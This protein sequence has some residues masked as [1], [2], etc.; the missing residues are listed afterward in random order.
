VQTIKVRIN[1]LRGLKGVRRWLRAAGNKLVPANLALQE[2]FGTSSFSAPVDF[3]AA[4]DDSGRLFVVEQGGTIRVLTPGATT[5]APVYLDIRDRVLFSGERG[6]L[7][8]TFHPN[9]E[10]N[11]FFYVNYT[12]SGDGAT[13]ISRF[14][15]SPASSNSVNASSEK[16]L[17]NVDQPFTNHNGGQVAFGADG[18]LYIAL[19]DGGSG[20]DPLGHGQ[21]RSTL[22]GS[23][24]RIDVDRSSGSRNYSIPSDNPFAGNTR[25]FKEEIYAYGLRNPWR[26]SFDRPTG[27]LWCGD[28]GQGAR[29]EVDIIE[30]GGNYGWNIMEG[31]LCYS[32]SE[33]CDRT[34]L[35]LPVDDYGRTLGA[36]ITGGYVYRGALNPALEGL[37]IFG[38]FVSGR[39]F[40]LNYTD[41]VASRR[42]LFDTS[43]LI[44]SFGVDRNG[45]L[46]MLSYGDGK[47][48]QFTSQ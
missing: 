42:E 36:S 26:I 48:Y 23:I 16:V 6:L 44:S 32:P 39:V 11:G 20:G 14:K 10:S 5:Q 30:N 1:K 40:S 19:G 28:V 29:E 47:I 18:Y 38:D 46:Y 41:G 15:A 37:Y 24:L 3:Q 34:G 17:L 2:V 4:P 21:N 8:L 9:F 35:T 7:A 31:S 27:R 25:G 12:R 13:T 45:E 22:L 43:I 33:N